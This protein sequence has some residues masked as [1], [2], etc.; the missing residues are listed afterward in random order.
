MFALAPDGVVVITDTLAT[1][2]PGDPYLL[3]TKCGIVPHLDLVVAGTGT[4]NLS[5]R[6][7]TMVYG[8]LLCR[9]IEMLDLHAPAALRDLWN[10]IQ[11]EFPHAADELMTSTVYHLGRSERT[12]EYV[13]FVYRSA[14]NFVSEP[15]GPGFRVKPEPVSQLTAAPESIEEMAELA[16]Q[17]RAEQNTLPKSERIHIGGELVLVMMQSGSTT[18]AKIHRYEDFENVWQEM[19]DLLAGS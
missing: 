3:V 4:A 18:A 14:D 15:M 17:I 16:H 8:H 5:E 7:R 10:E 6:W 2:V 19:N 9:D 11:K 12:G 13:G 1:T